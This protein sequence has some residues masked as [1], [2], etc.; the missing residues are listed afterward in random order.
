MKDGRE[1]ESIV[2]YQ[3]ENGQIVPDLKRAV[4]EI[5][6]SRNRPCIVYA[7]NM[8]RPIG[9]VG[10]A[11]DDSVPF[12]EMLN[13]I[14]DKERAI[15]IVLITPGGSGQQVANFV[16]TLRQRFQ[17]IDFIVPFM[18]MSAGTLWVLSGDNIWMEKNACVGPIDPQVPSKTGEYV[19]AQSILILLK[20]I[21]DE[22]AAAL[23][24]GE[25]PPWHYIR[26]IDMMDP[27]HV[28]EAINSSEYSV[29]LAAEFLSKYKFRNWQK[30]GTLVTDKE[31]DER[32]NAIAKLLC[33]NEHWKS[34]SHGITR[35]VV[36][37]DLRIQISHPED[38]PAF[39]RS[40]RRFWGLLYYTFERTNITKLYLAENYILMK[41][42]N[43]QV[44]NATP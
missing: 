30:N 1:F 6:A 18:C 13:S 15:D 20:R 42:S 5:Q 37:Q 16:H 26:M 35:P 11:L 31:K 38:E 3:P 8:I 24:R 4:Q 12:N 33:D 25:Q 34:H 41:Q 14:P 17:N 10:I 2:N 9:N 23:K 36:E 7:A 44:P 32:A 39:E 27:R 29:R 40:I 22:G 19:P 43:Q 21:H 28:G